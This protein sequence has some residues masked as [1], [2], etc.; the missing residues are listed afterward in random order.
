MTVALQNC[1]H[2]IPGDRATHPPHC[3]VV[4]AIALSC[5]DLY[6]NALNW[7]EILPECYVTAMWDSEEETWESDTYEA[8]TRLR[9]AVAIFWVEI[10]PKVEDE[11][12]A[13]LQANYSEE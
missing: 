6:R 4:C 8:R 1:T 12:L 7:D 2:F 9:N 5:N 11:I 10:V 3:D 13:Y